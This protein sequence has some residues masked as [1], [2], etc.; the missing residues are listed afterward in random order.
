[1]AGANCPLRL[2][3]QGVTGRGPHPSFR[4]RIVMRGAQT[5][6]RRF[7]NR[8][9]LS[10]TGPPDP[11]FLP[12]ARC[13]F[14]HTHNVGRSARS[15]CVDPDAQKFQTD[16]EHGCEPRLQ[17]PAPVCIVYRY[18]ADELPLAPSHPTSQK[19]LNMNFWHHLYS[20]PRSCKSTIHPFQSNDFP[21]IR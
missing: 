11:L 10:G 3:D 1:M 9:Y 16:C 19:G 6:T 20:C 21:V 5:A 15:P 13:A 8:Q 18:A 17:L 2:C 4:A 14:F 12:Q 7:G